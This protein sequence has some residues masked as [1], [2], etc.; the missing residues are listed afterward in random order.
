MGGLFHRKLQAKSI[1]GAIR[2]D[3]CFS[4]LT[5]CYH[6]STCIIIISRFNSAGQSKWVKT[7]IAQANCLNILH[8]REAAS[9]SWVM[10]LSSVRTVHL[11]EKSRSAK[12]VTSSLP[13]FF[14]G[15]I[16]VL[17]ALLIPFNIWDSSPFYFWQCLGSVWSHS[18]S[19][20]QCFIKDHKLS[21]WLE[22]HDFL[23]V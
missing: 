12:R 7:I 18:S 6:H 20:C 2:P 15:I 13:A 8:C 19:R 1:S 22:A 17:G 21:T 10:L 23:T 11:Q 16:E 4:C 5:F 3:W 14:N 9:P